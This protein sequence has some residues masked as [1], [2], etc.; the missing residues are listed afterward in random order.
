M[1][2]SLVAVVFGVLCTV[3]LGFWGGRGWRGGL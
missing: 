3:Q 2:F 1:V